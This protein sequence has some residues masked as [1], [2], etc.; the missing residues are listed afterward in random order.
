[1]GFHVGPQSTQSQCGL[2]KTEQ[3]R[4]AGVEGNGIQS[5]ADPLDTD[6]IMVTNV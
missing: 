2:D 1:M 3:G 6:G 4:A 5:M